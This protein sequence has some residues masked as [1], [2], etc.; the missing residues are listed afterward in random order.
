MKKTAMFLVILLSIVSFPQ[1]NPQWIIYNTS[2]SNLPSDN[3]R[4]IVVDQLNRKW[5]SFSSGGI[6]KIDSSS[7]TIYNTSNS[8][9]PSNSFN[10]INADNESNFWGGYG[11]LLTKFDGT[12]W[13]VYGIPDSMP[14][15]HSISS[16]VF[17]G[18]NNVWFLK[19]INGSIGS[20]H[21][22]IEF[23][24][25]SLWATHLSLQLGNG[26]RQLLYNDQSIWIG[27]GEGLYL[28]ENDS[29]QYF[30]PQTGPVGLYC[31]DVKSDS[32]NNIWFATGLAGWGNL[33]KFDG[34]NYT[35]YNYMATAIEF[36][37]AGNLWVGTES[38]TNS[39]ELLKFDGTNL[40]SF[41]STNSQ[42]PQTFGINDLAFDEF[43][44][45]WIATASAGLVVFNEHGITPVEL[46]SFIASVNQ[47]NVTLNWQT[48]TETNNQGF[49]IE[50]RKTEDE[51][52]NEW[53]IIGF[54]N[55]NGTTTESHSYSFIDENLNEGLYQYRLKQIDFDGTYKYY[56]LSE[57]V[58]IGLLNKFEL[59][60]NYPNPFN[61]STKIKFTIPSNVNGEMSNVVLKIFDVL[62]N[63]VATLVN[64]NKQAG[65]YEIEFQSTAGGRQL[66]S[67]VYYY[68]LKVGEF[69][70]TKKMILIK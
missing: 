26:Y 57:S 15:G 54:V 50:R 37:S 7:W 28:F 70:D 41:N 69:V 33:L 2:N 25:D 66:A 18:L 62:G 19:N 32:L 55:G 21:Y 23:R 34:T 22:L 17:D 38:F 47:N 13:S 68:Q 4:D 12:D 31:T 6:L 67:G 16:I 39:S 42:L 8:N 64:E 27:D 11:S 10:T 43:G 30:Q 60:Q 36:D 49:Q 14:P 61:P 40:T 65:S 24:D 59:S 1:S 20:T 58:E 5:I 9:I 46:S 48:A 53:N 52:S 44:N 56:D 63:E 45:L 35:T 51:K 29:L 3:V